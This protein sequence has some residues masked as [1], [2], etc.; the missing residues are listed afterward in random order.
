VRIQVFPSDKLKIEPWLVNGWQSYGKFNQAPGLGLQILWRPV[1][2]LAILGNQ[3]VGTDTLGTPDRKRIHTDDSIMVKYYENQ[4]GVISKAAASLTIDLGCEWGGGV[5]CSSG[6]AAAPS[7]FFLGFMAYNRIWFFRD[8][9]GLTIGGGAINNPGRYLV[10]MPPINGATAFTGSPY[11]TENPGDPYKAWDMQIS[12]D[13]SPVPFVAFRLEYNHRAASVPYFS[14][15]GGVTPPGGNN[16]SPA[17]W[18]YNPDA[19]LW[20]PDLIPTEDRISLALLVR[21]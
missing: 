8:R 4:N 2:W 10:L 1:S 7:Q 13:Y 12:A 20:R 16:G 21:L 15:P 5:S 18:A 6:N 3:Y 19:S 14:G 17:T 11:F 9:F